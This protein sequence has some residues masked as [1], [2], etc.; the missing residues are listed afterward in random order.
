MSL[1][2]NSEEQRF[3]LETVAITFITINTWIKI[4]ERCRCLSQ[5]EISWSLKLLL[6]KME[7]SGL[8]S[9]TSWRGRNWSNL[10]L[11][12]QNWNWVEP[13]GEVQTTKIS[14][15]LLS[16]ISKAT[17]LSR[18]REQIGKRAQKTMKIRLKSSKTW[19]ARYNFHRNNLSITRNWQEKSEVFLKSHQNW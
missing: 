12:K 6:S 11:I 3:V 17:Q 5:G 9:F 8:I 15:N 14:R 16:K 4:L 7:L 1:M 18:K 13:I 10:T 2:T 19:K